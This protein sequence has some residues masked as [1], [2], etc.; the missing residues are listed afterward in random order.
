MC[1]AHFLRR[2][3]FHR[4]RKSGSRNRVHAHSER[5][6]SIFL[7][8]E[9]SIR[10]RHFVLQ[11]RRHAMDCSTSGDSCLPAA[12]QACSAM[13]ER[14]LS[15]RA[16]RRTR[17]DRFPE[18]PHR[19]TPPFARLILQRGPRGR[20]RNGETAA[21]SEVRG[22]V[23]SQSRYSYSRS[24][25]AFRCSGSS[26]LKS[27]FNVMSGRTLYLV[28]TERLF[29]NRPD[30]FE[31]YSFIPGSAPVTGSPCAS[32]DLPRPVRESLDQ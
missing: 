11:L 30:P 19:K 6:S 28:V 15:G 18:K 25:I 3:N 8:S 22:A 2:P 7:L 17:G 32:T 31:K 9:Y 29:H 26:V 1:R 14:P 12:V 13:L 21:L 5:G 23:V 20:M 27:R 16:L 4:E 24:Q 10:L